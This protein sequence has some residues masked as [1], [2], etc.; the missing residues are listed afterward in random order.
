MI[1]AAQI[2]SVIMFF[3]TIIGK[4]VSIGITIYTKDYSTPQWPIII[5]GSLLSVGIWGLMAY[6]LNFLI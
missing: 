1:L 5:L 6:V 2:I 3:K 4:S